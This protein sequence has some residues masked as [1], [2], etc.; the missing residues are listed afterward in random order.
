MAV[1]GKPMTVIEKIFCSLALSLA[2]LP[3]LTGTT[4]AEDY[5]IDVKGQHAFI[6]FKVPH[7]DF[8]YIIGSFT[9]FNGEFSYDENDPAATTINIT[10]DTASLD[11][12]HA[13]RDK[14]LRSSRY[15]DVKNYPEITFESSSFRESADG[16]V[17][18]TGNLSFHGITKTID[19]EAKHIGHGA[20]PWGG[21]RRGLEAWF[22][23]KPGDYGFPDWIG[24]AEVYVVG[25][26]IRQ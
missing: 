3:L 25:E 11:S 12:N 8:S 18:I 13:E 23:L 21:Y 19:V 6:Q 20:D 14:H 5:V 15:F 10:I 24:D 17:V 22:T 16:T 1:I 7:F 4:W 9:R 2:T 26:G